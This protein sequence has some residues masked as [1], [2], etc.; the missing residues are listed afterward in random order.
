MKTNKEL[1][2]QVDKLTKQLEIRGY[3]G[4]DNDDRKYIA[5]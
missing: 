3:G 1:K 2:E 4:N 5:Q